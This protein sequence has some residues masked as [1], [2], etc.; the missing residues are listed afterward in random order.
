MVN[1]VTAGNMV[2]MEGSI[3]MR[4]RDSSVSAQDVIAEVRCMIAGWRAAGEV[5]AEAFVDALDDHL[6]M[7]A[8]RK[9]APASPLTEIRKRCEAATP[10]PWYP[11]ATDDACCM[12]ARYVSLVPGEWRHDDENGMA[13][14]ADYANVVAITLLQSP[15]LACLDDE[16]WDE[17][18]LF[19]AHARSG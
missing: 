17:N 9:E 11:K 13:E 6:A 18:T 8:E 16:K 3:E 19:I 2:E 4:G 5:S 7:L 12:N 10:G 15:R 1:V 14:P